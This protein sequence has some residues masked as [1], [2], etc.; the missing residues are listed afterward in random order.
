MDVDDIGAGNDATALLCHTSNTG[1]CGESMSVSGNWHFP[2][3]TVVKNET[4][5]KQVNNAA[6]NYFARNSG[7][8]VVRL[9][10]VGNPTN[11]GHFYCIVPNAA[12]DN[13]T[14]Y[15]NLCKLTIIGSVKNAT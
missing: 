10:R 6:S 7:A 2:D 15:V 4:S 1:C 13:Q 12:G 11:K 9:Y 8:G 14:I 5:I 3:G